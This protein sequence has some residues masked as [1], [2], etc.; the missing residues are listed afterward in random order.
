MC[1]NNHRNIR[2]T[3][4]SFQVN[5]LIVDC[6]LVRAA[7]FSFP[8]T[9]ASGCLGL[10]PEHLQ[11]L[12]TSD[13]SGSFLQRITSLVNTLLGG[14][15][16][17]SV[18]RYL[19]G[20][21]LIALVKEPDGML[22]S[23]YY[24]FKICNLSTTV[25]RRCLNR[26]QCES[27]N[28]QI[29][30][31]YLKTAL[32]DLSNC[33]IADRLSEHLTQCIHDNTISSLISILNLDRMERNSVNFSLNT[34][35]LR[36]ADRQIN[37]KSPIPA[38]SIDRQIVFSAH[39]CDNDLFPNQTTYTSVLT[40]KF[41]KKWLEFYPTNLRTSYNLPDNFIS[42]ELYIFEYDKTAMMSFYTSQWR[43]N[44]DMINYENEKRLLKCFF[45]SEIPEINQVYLN[46]ICSIDCLLNRA[47]SNL[48][49]FLKLSIHVEPCCGIPR[50]VLSYE[51]VVQ[52]VI[53]YLILSNPHRKPS[54]LDVFC[55]SGLCSL[56]IAGFSKYVIG[57]D[58]STY[59]CLKTACKNK[60][61]NEIENCKFYS[62]LNLDKLEQKIT[63]EMV[64]TVI[65]NCPR[66]DIDA[67]ARN[68]R[69]SLLNGF[70]LNDRINCIIVIIPRI[71]LAMLHEVYLLC[72][73]IS[74]LY[75]M[76]GEPFH[77]KKIKLVNDVECEFYTHES[78][79]IIVV[80]N[81][82]FEICML[83]MI[84]KLYFII[85]LALYINSAASYCLSQNISDQWPIYEV[86][87]NINGFL[88][89]PIH[90]YPWMYHCTKGSDVN[91]LI[92][93]YN[94][95]NISNL[96][97]SKK[98][99][100][101][102]GDV[103]SETESVNGINLSL[104]TFELE[105]RNITEKFYGQYTLVVELTQNI[106]MNFGYDFKEN[107]T[108]LYMKSYLN[109]YL[110]LFESHHEEYGINWLVG[111]TTSIGFFSFVIVVYLFNRFKYKEGAS[112]QLS[113]NETEMELKRG[114]SNKDLDI[115]D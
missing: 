28:I 47:V 80:K 44:H 39:D 6:S 11:D 9:S 29:K 16:H 83:T 109:M 14:G 79:H 91:L 92:W 5:S 111:L 115:E 38:M 2:S 4:D 25:T 85:T 114:I 56:S 110:P 43:T 77:L 41:V 61:L 105:I 102:G 23:P 3:L 87:P 62:L 57:I 104:S 88:K 93:S 45:D 76:R 71:S 51:K 66:I 35:R 53:D 58:P 32:N 90:G 49:K 60:E 17:E 52:L 59:T 74:Q 31:A 81:I 69:R 65:L 46:R 107:V 68:Y 99:V 7:I 78:K 70:R 64:D 112:R 22:S 20:A 21:N 75:C 97:K 73:P 13:L 103:V 54:V 36:S 94:L 18:A 42:C 106:E 19:C 98:W 67:S 8:S 48:Q 86:D 100:I 82:I 95:N 113:E 34:K 72:A 30:E 96:I 55:G 15:G 24:R 63:E 1:I 108:T 27:N 12:L 50:C 37:S 84:L 40:S 10:R 26:Y 89:S 33:W 101:P